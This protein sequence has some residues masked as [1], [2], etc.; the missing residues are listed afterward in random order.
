MKKIGIS[1]TD[2][3]KSIKGIPSRNESSRFDLRPN[4]YIVL[5]R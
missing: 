3:R 1:I 4:S 5:I 2:C